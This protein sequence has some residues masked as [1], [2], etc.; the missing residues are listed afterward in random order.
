MN[1]LIRGTNWIGDAVMTIPAIR[2]LRRTFPEARLTLQT[3][4]WA[5]GIFRDTRLVDEVISPTS[6]LDQ[7]RAFR[8]RKFDLAVI[9]PNSFRSA[10]TTRLGG[11][12]RIF[13]YASDS[14]SM[15]LTDAVAIPDWKDR[16]HEVFYYLELISAV[17]KAWFGKT[18]GAVNLLPWID[19]SEESRNR[20]RQ[21]L[22]DNG[23][24]LGGQVIAIAPGST[25]SEAKRWH[26]ESFAR[27]A[28]L[29]A[30]AGSTVVLLGS[31]HERDVTRRVADLTSAKVIDLTGK[32]SIA[33]AAAVLAHVDLLVSN[34]MG[35][36]HLAPAVGTWTTVIFG[37]TDPVTTRPFSDLADVVTANV[38]C[39]PCMLRKCP[40]DHRCMTRIS[41]DDVFKRVLMG[42]ERRSEVNILSFES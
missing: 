3:R 26:T 33:E 20:G 5:E 31:A 36:A 18:A 4:P 37:P 11:A 14:R 21:I 30:E 39:A 34:D 23:V 29:I 13:G 17:E 42:L 41:P 2:K 27:L 12:T 1:I 24:A 8:Q 22:E 16:R 40:I 19:L 28:D 9:F 35:L 38:E 6:L 25:N 15:L 10:L 32:T 7:V